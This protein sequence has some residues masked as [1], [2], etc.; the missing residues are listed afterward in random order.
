MSKKII[1]Q[2]KATKK[3]EHSNILSEVNQRYDSLQNTQLN[4]EKVSAQSRE[5]YARYLAKRKIR[6]EDDE[7][8]HLSNA[9]L[10]ISQPTDLGDSQLAQSVDEAP[11][12]IAQ[13]DSSAAATEVK[14]VNTEGADGSTQ[15]SSS[16]TTAASSTVSTGLGLGLLGVV[17]AG[18]SGGGGG[19][20]GIAPDVTSPVLQSVGLSSKSNSQIV[21]TYDE[22]LNEAQVALPASFAVT[23][24]GV[25]NAVTA[26][27]VSGR[28]VT[29]TL[30]NAVRAGEE[31]VVNFTDPTAGNDP[32]TIQDLAG[33]DAA[34]AS[35]GFTMAALS[36][37]Y[38]RG[39]KIYVDTNGNGVAEPSEYTGVTTNA[40]G[41][42]VLPASSA[43]GV[44]IAVGGINIDTGVP[45]VV[46]L[47]A[48][49][50]SSVVTPLTTLVQEVFASGGGALTV[51]TATAQVVN[52]LNLTPGT[53]LTSYD[54]LAAADVSIQ[55]AAAS[56]GTILSIVAGTAATES[57]AAAAV[58]KVISNISEQIVQAVDG[59]N[60]VV[61]TDNDTIAAFLSDAV[62]A[63]AVAALTAVIDTA[64]E[65]IDDALSLDAISNSQAVALDVLA[66]SAPSA[67]SLSSSSDTGKT[68]DDLTNDSTPTIRVALDTT[69]E[70]GTAAV[71]NNVVK[72]F[73]G[74]NLVGQATLSSNNIADGYVDV[75]LTEPLSE[76]ETDLTVT[77]TDIASNTS[78]ASAEFTVSVDTTSPQSPSLSSNNTSDGWVN[79]SEAATTVIKVAL[80][81][82]GS[83][84]VA[85][86][87]VSI[88]GGTKILTSTISAS[89]IS[90]GYVDFAVEASYFGEDGSKSITAKVTDVAGNLSAASVAL[91]FTLD[92]NI[93]TPTLVLK[94]DT[95]LYDDDKLTNSGE[96]TVD[97]AAA[98]VTRTYSLDGGEAVSS[99]TAPT[100]GGSHTLVI[101]DIDTAGNTT[102]ASITFTLDLTAPKI[103]S[104][105]PIDDSVDVVTS[106]ISL[107]FDENV[108][109]G[110]GDI[111]IT[112]ES[113]QQ[114][115]S[116]T[117]DTQV[118]ISGRVVTITPSG[119]LSPAAS[120][121]VT[122]ASGVIT[123]VAG[124]AF[125]GLSGGEL[126]FTMADLPTISVSTSESDGILNVGDSASISFTLSAVSTDFSA[127]DV[128]VN[129]GRLENFSGSGL[130]YTATLTPDTNSTTNATVTVGAGK[131]TVNTLPNL[132]SN[133]LTLSVDTV[134]PV[135]PTVSLQ[136]DSGTAAD[137][138][139]NS[140]TI[141]VG[142]VEEG[143][144]WKYSTDGGGSWSAGVGSTF[145]VTGDGTKSVLVKQV[146]SH[147]NESAETSFS[148]TLDTTIAKPTVD[149]ASNSGSKEDSVTNSALISESTKAND[150]TRQY[151]LDNGAPTSTYTPPSSAGVHT[152]VVVDTD[153]AGNTATSD[154][155]SF[156]LD[157]TAPALTATSPEDGS[158]LV[159]PSANIVFSFNEDVVAGTG[160]II[161]SDGE[162]ELIIPATDG[163][164]SISGGVVTINPTANLALTTQYHVSFA[165]GV[166]TDVAGNLIPAKSID[167]TTASA[168]TLS[169]SLDDVEN[170]DVTS[171]I[172][173]TASE[174]VD[175]VAGKFIRIVNDGGDGYRGES[176]VN[177]LTIDVT[178]N[179]VS[180]NG[181]LIVINPSVDLDFNN[182][183][184]I[185]VDAGAFVGTVSGQA[186]L[187]VDN[188]SSINFSTVLPSSSSSAQ[189]SQKMSLSADE[190]VT[191]Y[192]W[193]DAEGNGAP[194]S[195]A[196][197]RDFSAGDM[198]IVANDLLPAGDVD[199]IS[200]NDFYIAVNNF[201]A[202]DLIYID[203][204]GDNS[205]DRQALFEGGLI[206]DLGTPPTQVATAASGTAS[207][208]NGGQFD[209]T[210]AAPNAGS[211]FSEIEVL[212]TLLQID[213]T[214]IH[215]G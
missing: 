93:D 208:Q 163:Q 179:Q 205:L 95:G 118:S 92:T 149:L 136:S 2:S 138:I 48:P 139:T 24:G 100:V 144:T 43:S 72:V 51:E 32:N 103:A 174:V 55:K 199:G 97:G 13:A 180:V 45:N 147:E 23:T 74:A 52:A 127:N 209:I 73:A 1:E 94:S 69:K 84:A 39:A 142:G 196:V 187:A 105:K 56:V 212:K 12:V 189:A 151:K 107:T 81:T 191:S 157:T 25:A 116:I 15:N 173:L 167:F 210:L 125:S 161:I 113:G 46:P 175:A 66:P 198:A 61:L 114:T 120:Y 8:G 109:A 88:Y 59:G 65:N 160:N 166:F 79:A 91:S 16:S 162:T 195:T 141:S 106:S 169:S 131:F 96:I 77:V 3:L 42:F 78:D 7:N 6:E 20:G 159:S 148:F 155:L 50:G 89:D 102:S 75:T 17:A 183:Y 5:T 99:Y 214:P 90:K 22:S 185:E 188:E 31:V 71:V 40:L 104:T 154:T 27:S 135:A 181:K 165:A 44:I 130:T 211:T 186:S 143:G 158:E 115:I 129:G 86:D 19:G 37:G 184:H 33:N 204:K 123:D 146:D 63:D 26:V 122:V 121:S 70:D 57:A 192:S 41:G 76:G 207:G 60:N 213:Y 36:D 62:A 111:V 38:I 171:S 145:S 112:G 172:V 53:D 132:A 182:T 49:A 133:T 215:Y 80:P 68:G 119:A 30:T 153:T 108:A 203:N 110:S 150:V 117:D 137:K 168:P 152:V 128:T 54:A 194:G 47:K 98:D 190:M 164:V 14:D 58:K 156:T 134:A 140:G 21:L 201:S 29:L 35:K 4:T 11:L 34:T 85:G 28:L 176:T 177:T 178:S 170:F 193:W 206:V 197:V 202:G 101:N 124:N 82:S 10:K 18:V 64:A 9:N 126:N 83:L 200:T 87:S 67:L